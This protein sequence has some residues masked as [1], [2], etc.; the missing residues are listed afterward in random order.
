MKI[1]LPYL[2]LMHPFTSLAVAIV[3]VI[4]AISSNP[5]FDL[6][7]LFLI[8]SVMLTVQFSIGVSND[9]LDQR[10]DSKAKPWKPIPS[11]KVGKRTALI[12]FASLVI[13][14]F[15]SCSILGWVPLGIMLFGLC[16]GMA[17]NLGLKRTL[18]SWLPLSLAVPTILVWV[19]AI[20]ENTPNALYWSYPLGLLLGPAL[21]LANQLA[22]AE[23]AAHSGERSL[24]HFL[25]VVSGRRVA[26]GL[27]VLV[28]AFMPTVV[29]INDLQVKV[30]TV[31][32]VATSLFIVVF[33]VLAEFDH[34]LVLWPLAI[35]IASVQGVFFLSA[36]Q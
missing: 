5:P 32:S 26:V 28:S 13:C 25:G 8:G 7:R 22:G 29:W 23:E 3:T 21:N 12:I 33:A 14:S 27:F 10:Y 17:Y 19:G 4:I 30:A 20:N 31:G 2:R 16:C 6:H 11:K 9:V 34:R 1:L 15:A 36:I 18:F 35:L 24:M